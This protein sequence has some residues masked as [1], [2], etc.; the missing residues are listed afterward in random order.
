MF[1]IE[2]F[3]E[4][5][6]VFNTKNFLHENNFLKMIKDLTLF[7]KKNCEK[8]KRFIQLFFSLNKIKKI[9]D[10]PFL[11]VQ[12]FKTNDLKSIASK[13]V[14]KKL[15]SSGTSGT[16]KSKI[17]LDKN[18]AQ[19]QIK[20]LSKILS[21]KFGRTRHPMLVVDR[22]PL[23]VSKKEFSASVAAIHGFSLI[24]SKKYYL[25]DENN[26][27]NLKILNE[28]LTKYSSKKFFIFGFTSLIYQHLIKDLNP[29]KFKFKNAV[30]IHGG[31]WKKLEKL[32]ISNKIFKNKLYK[33]FQI[34]EV[35]NYY[36][37]V[38]QTG[39]IF[40]E[41]KFGY[42][43]NSIFSDLIIR[44][45]NFEI[46][47]PGKKGL[48]QLI[49]VLPTSYPGHSIITEDVGEVM[50]SKFKCKCGLNSKHFLVYGRAKEAETR[51]CSDTK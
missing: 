8:Y 26:K 29:S 41:C 49:S 21:N 42:F 33:K 19:N 17:Y 34:K 4:K 43:V 18:N 44:D 22:N 20:A 35:V 6:E 46:L 10:V 51:G 47:T 7:H 38:E 50:S 48:I 30:L 16:N 24:A 36:G 1:K 32:K 14:F 37:L 31:G 15:S 5:E 11:P 23:E 28:F 27:I 40:F 12:I 9:E 2:K 25:L 3:F 39:S 45:K 13:E